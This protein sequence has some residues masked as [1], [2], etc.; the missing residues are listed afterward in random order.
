MYN[1]TL[2]DR[3]E[4][5]HAGRNRTTSTASA[6]EPS[7]RPVEGTAYRKSYILYG[8]YLVAIAEYKGLLHANFAAVRKPLPASTPLQNPSNGAIDFV[9]VFSSFCFRNPVRS[10]RP[11]RWAMKYIRRAFRR[12]NPRPEPSPRSVPSLRLLVN[13]TR[14]STYKKTCAA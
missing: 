8:V 13:C 3:H 5:K 14:A 4:G 1:T 11:V 6:G 10:L 12:P 2:G 7:C 9:H